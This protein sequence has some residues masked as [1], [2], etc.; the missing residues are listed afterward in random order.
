[1]PTRKSLSSDVAPSSESRRSSMKRL[2]SI[3]SL[4]HLNPFNRRRSNNA[5]DST[6]SLAS[7]VSLP[8][9]STTIAAPSE[10]RKPSES[11]STFFSD[12]T[13]LAAPNI[14][15]ESQASFLRRSSYV[16]LPDD[17]IGGM[18]RS[19]TFSN[20]PVPT[21]RKR[22]DFRIPSTTHNRDCSKLTSSTR[23][24]TPPA[25]TRKHLIG[26]IPT[27]ASRYQSV[28]NRM[29]RSDT[30]P[31][32]PSNLDQ[33]SS[34][35]RPTAFKENLSVSMTRPLPELEHFDEAELSSPLS[36]GSYVED[37]LWEQQAPTV[38]PRDPSFCGTLPTAHFIG[39]SPPRDASTFYSSPAYHMNQGYIPRSSSFS[40]PVPVQRWNSQPI[41]A[42]TTN[43]RAN[44]H[45]EIR[46]TRLLSARQAPTPP[47]PKA[48]LPVQAIGAPA[49][50]VRG[51]SV[52]ASVHHL[53]RSSTQTLLNVS[54]SPQPSAG[55]VAVAEPL[56]YWCGR[57]SAMV[58]RYR[59]QDLAV[60][61][62]N[63]DAKSETDKLHTPAAHTARL[64]RALEH[65]HA[66]CVTEEAQDSFVRFQMQFAAM[67][68]LPEL[69]R[70]IGTKKPPVAS[71]S[72]QALPA[73]G[74]DHYPGK[75][76]DLEAGGFAKS[77]I[78]KISLFDR[79]LGR[80]EKRES[81]V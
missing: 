26:S 38:L 65:L 17:P 72:S 46:Q 21:R 64:R 70:P 19:R 24:P 53:R 66:Q 41:L 47:L 12:P 31:L 44:A 20:L 61:L 45:H 4:A 25:S 79:M 78:R 54:S 60:T 59:N 13:P 80:R 55:Q 3:A 14:P 15:I 52:S 51:N 73:Y 76:F 56:S 10:S 69:G 33:A 50:R 9:G 75:K 63:P 40:R 57:I 2:S 32:L 27:A 6:A 29:K 77:G 74:V 23:L 67:Q 18:P 81:L 62:S 58:D 68:N 43:I 34:L 5:T 8:S 39:S 16:C 1:M 36:A 22:S 37:Q 71:K 7:E 49:T 48:P 42:N 11:S 35:P 28:R 30:M